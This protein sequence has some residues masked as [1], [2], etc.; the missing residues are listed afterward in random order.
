M[1]NIAYTVG[2]HL[3]TL[4]NNTTAVG[5]TAN[6]TSAFD[7][8]LR[9]YKISETPTTALTAFKYEQLSSYSAADF[10]NCIAQSTSPKYFFEYKTVT[11]TA[12]PYE[13]YIYPGSKLNMEIR[14]I[15]DITLPETESF[16]SFSCPAR[17]YPSYN[18]SATS[19]YAIDVLKLKLNATYVDL[20]YSNIGKLANITSYNDTYRLRLGGSVSSMEPDT[21]TYYFED[22]PYSNISAYNVSCKIQHSPIGHYPSSVVARYQVYDIIEDCNIVFELNEQRSSDIGNKGPAVSSIKNST[23]TCGIISAKDAENTTF[24][25]NGSDSLDAISQISFIDGNL[26]SCNFVNYNAGTRYIQLSNSTANNC[27]FTDVTRITASNSYIDG[28]Y[29]SYKVG[30]PSSFSAS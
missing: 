9:V 17:A 21:H 14:G 12:I 24:N 20:R 22:T 29:Y 7:G 15:T 2:G 3:A 30:A 13:N 4:Y 28:T 25:M 11:A 23:L 26:S 19:S 27:V 8:I 10:T 6:Y 18:V 16:V 1:T 5:T